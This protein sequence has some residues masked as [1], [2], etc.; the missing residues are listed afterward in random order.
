MESIY[1]PIINIVKQCKK[2]NILVA[3]KCGAT[4]R[5]VQ[6]GLLDLKWHTSNDFEYLKMMYPDYKGEKYYQNEPAVTDGKLITASGMAPLEF[7][8]YVLIALGVFLPIT[9]D[10]WYKLYETNEA[11]Y[12]HELM[13][14]YNKN[15]VFNI[16]SYFESKFL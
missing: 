16:L 12:F 3:A 2:E 8:V 11:K 13:I 15:V 6:N 1:E 7:A 4:I 9:L 10:I 14:Q 5:L